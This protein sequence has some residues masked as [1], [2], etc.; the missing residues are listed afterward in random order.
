MFLK[1]FDLR[2]YALIDMS[3]LEPLSFCLNGQSKTTGLRSF[4]PFFISLIWKSFLWVTSSVDLTVCSCAFLLDGCVFSLAVLKNFV[5]AYPF[6]IVYHYF[7]DLMK[8]AT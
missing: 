8:E 4:I 6:I 7:I 1:F 5:F 3:L 2:L